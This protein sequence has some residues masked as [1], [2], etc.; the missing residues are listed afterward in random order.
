MHFFLPSF[1]ILSSDWWIGL[2]PVSQLADLCPLLLPVAA[3]QMMSGCCSATC[4]WRD[5]PRPLPHLTSH[6]S[7]HH[8]VPSSSS[9]PPSVRF[10]SRWIFQKRK[11]APQSRCFPQI[12]PPL[13]HDDIHVVFKTT[14]I[15][16][17]TTESTESSP[18][19]ACLA[20]LDSLCSGRRSTV[21]SRP[22]RPFPR[23]VF[24]PV[25]CLPSF[26]AAA[27]PQTPTAAPTCSPDTLECQT[28][29]QRWQRTWGDKIKE[30][31]DSERTVEERRK[32]EGETNRTPCGTLCWGRPIT[33]EDT[34]GRWR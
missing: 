30:R 12:P 32:A 31:G 1:I 8:T 28:L 13:L 21:S 16:D 25:T 26:S 6:P 11:T 10:T 14:I 33:P 19:A 3:A 4:L 17:F 23:H 5:R 15:D 22:R 9:H 20:S 7:A 2:A 24:T 18:P 34:R 27:A 29:Y